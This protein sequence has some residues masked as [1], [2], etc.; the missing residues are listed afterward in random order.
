M[1]YFKFI[2]LAEQ[3]VVNIFH[4]FLLAIKRARDLKKKKKS[5][6]YNDADI[7]QHVL[8]PLKKISLG[9]RK[10]NYYLS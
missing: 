1:K 3:R 2:K 4:L 8:I 10:K 9:F 7:I 5:Y 6:L